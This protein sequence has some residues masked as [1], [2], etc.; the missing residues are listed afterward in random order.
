MFSVTENIFSSFNFDTIGG[1]LIHWTVFYEPKELQ[2]PA[3]Q[4]HA[5]ANLS[6]VQ[7]PMELP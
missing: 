2:T 1:I 3:M 6:R 4:A 5:S 7:D